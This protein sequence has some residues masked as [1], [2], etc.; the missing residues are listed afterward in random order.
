MPAV[1]RRCRGRFVA[2]EALDDER[3]QR[4]R[5]HREDDQDDLHL[6]RR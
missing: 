3:D 4:R 2:A 1:A 6:S 5:V